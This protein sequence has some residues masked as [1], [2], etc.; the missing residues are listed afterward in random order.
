MFHVDD[1]INTSI[2]GKITVR[3]SKTIKMAQIVPTTDELNAHVALEEVCIRLLLKA[4]IKIRDQVSQAIPVYYIFLASFCQYDQCRVRN[5]RAFCDRSCSSGPCL[6]SHMHVCTVR[7]RLEPFSCIRDLFFKVILV[8]LE[9]LDGLPGGTH[10][11]R[12]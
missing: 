12:S 9:A 6:A 5:C 11:P 3:V 8:K 7:S 2:D 1:I 4:V 10:P